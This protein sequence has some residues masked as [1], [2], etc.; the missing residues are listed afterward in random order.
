MSSLL[1]S[2]LMR[3]LES[4]QHGA[5]STK[6]AQEMTIKS[7]G[8]WKPSE[9]AICLCHVQCTGHQLHVSLSQTEVSMQEQRAPTSQKPG[10]SL[11]C[12]SCKARCWS[13]GSPSGNSRTCCWHPVTPRSCLNRMVVSYLLSWPPVTRRLRNYGKQGTIPEYSRLICRGLQSGPQF[14]HLSNE[15]LGPWGW[16]KISLNPSTPSSLSQGCRPCVERGTKVQKV[17]GQH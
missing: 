15:G 11:S 13:G 8:F 10:I 2:D 17:H 1:K 4:S 16:T 12:S 5:W 3:G 9:R 6:G 7:S 14:V